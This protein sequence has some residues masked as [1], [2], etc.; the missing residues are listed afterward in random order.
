MPAQ[1]QFFVGNQTHQFALRRIKGLRAVRQ[2]GFWARLV[3]RIQIAFLGHQMPRS[4]HNKLTGK[5]KC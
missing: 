3:R 1:K 5:V 4:P 2:L